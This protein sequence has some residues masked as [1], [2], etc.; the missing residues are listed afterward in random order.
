MG[1]RERKRGNCLKLKKKTVWD[2]DQK[3]LGPLRYVAQKENPERRGKGKKEMVGEKG[4][5]IRQS[6]KEKG[7]RKRQSGERL[8]LKKKRQCGI[9]ERKL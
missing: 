1:R 7:F 4:N 9:S 8:K 5:W 2:I 3:S 6:E